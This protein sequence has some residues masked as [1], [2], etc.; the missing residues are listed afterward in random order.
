M[1]SNAVS[2]SACAAM[3]ARAC[4]Y[5]EQSAPSDS[6]RVAFVTPDSPQQTNTIL[7][8]LKPVV[9]IRTFQTTHCHASG[10]RQFATPPYLASAI[11][12]AVL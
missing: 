1:H 11:T 12:R 4:V 10:H 9:V 6:C 2:V 8:V 7:H 3:R 5:A